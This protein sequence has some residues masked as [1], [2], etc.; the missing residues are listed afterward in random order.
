M[1]EDW[2]RDGADGGIMSERGQLLLR[3]LQRN[4]ELVRE[5]EKVAPA[6]VDAIAVML[7]AHVRSWRPLA[8]LQAGALC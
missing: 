1:G 3:A 6:E 7:V 5:H 2:I 8:L 4:L